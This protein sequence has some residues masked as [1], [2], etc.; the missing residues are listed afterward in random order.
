VTQLGRNDYS[1]NIGKGRFGDKRVLHG[2][3]GKIL[4]R[5][6]KAIGEYKAN[7]TL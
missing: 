4:R 1:P 5:N 7:I 2:P 6:V 3:V